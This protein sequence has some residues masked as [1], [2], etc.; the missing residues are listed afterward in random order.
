MF[1]ALCLV[2]GLVCLRL[3]FW[4][5]ARLEQRRAHSR[6]V[7]ARQSLPRLRLETA[8]PD[9]EV[10]F[11]SVVARGRFDSAHQVVLGNRAREGRPGL[12][13]VTPLRLEGSEWSLL[14]D[15]GWIP[16]ESGAIGDLEAYTLDGVVEVSGIA[17]PTQVEPGWRFLADRATTLQEPLQIWR[18]L[19]VPGIQSQIPYPLL[20][21]FL[22][23]REPA[24]GLQ[25]PVPDVEIDLSEGPH[26]GYALQWFAFSSIALLGGGIWL[27]R[28]ARGA[29]DARKKP[30]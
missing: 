5:L 17:L 21:Y 18:V 14:I 30:E 2:L 4:Q 9:A 19:F 16:S 1:A 29:R 3:G 12:H 22:A 13:L 23:Q 11:R 28:G 6:L 24:G 20:P 10:P 27:L 15:R 8:I 7:Q 26:L 25:G